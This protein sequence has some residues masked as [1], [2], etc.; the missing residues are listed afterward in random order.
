MTEGI[1]EIIRVIAHKLWAV[2]TLTLLTCFLLYWFYGVLTALP[3]LTF[4]FAGILYNAEDLL[5]YYPEIPADS[6]VFVPQPSN[7]KLPFESIK[8]PN[9][10]GFMI[11]MFFIKQH[12]NSS[13]LPTIVF[14]HGNA[15][16]IGHRLPNVS[17]LFHKLN[18]NILLLEYRGYGLSEGVPSEDGLYSDAQ[19]AINYLYERSDIDRKQIILFGRSLGGAVAIDLASRPEY[20]SKIWC[21]IVE[22]TFTSIPD[23]VLVLLGWRC[24]RWLPRCIHKNQYMSL[25]KVSKVLVPSM[26][27][28]GSSDSLVPPAMG[29][30]LHF[31]CAAIHKRL[32]VIP[33]GGHNDTWT[34]REYY[35]SLQQFISNVP[36]MPEFVDKVMPFF[37]KPQLQ[38]PLKHA[39][40]YT[41]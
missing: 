21:L 36:P 31:R 35:P 4:G 20:R 41:V 16:N 3:L 22:N 2:S 19:T 5:L 26:F 17:G 30:A 18:V 40:V 38:Q 23:M 10:D 27:I 8:I 29:E 39:T 34:C 1:I 32:L 37:D 28:C 24:L 7:Y 15:G 9:K 12:T 33:G 13:K 6:R 25:Q 11:H 14:F